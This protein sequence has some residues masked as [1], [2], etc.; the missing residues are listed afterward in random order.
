MFEFAKAASVAEADHILSAIYQESPKFWAAGLTRQHFDGGLWLIRKQASGEAIGFTGWQVRD[1]LGAKGMR[2]VGYYA[3]GLLPE[4]RGNGFAKE[5]VSRMLAQK[6]AEVDIVRALIHPDNAPS[7]ALA[8]RLGVEVEK[9]ARALLKAVGRGLGHETSKMVGT[10]L[11]TAVFH[12]QLMH[13][14]QP[15]TNSLKPWEWNKE[16]LMVGGVNFGMGALGRHYMANG[17]KALGIAT[18]SAGPIA[19]DVLMRTHGAIDSLRRIADKPQQ[20]QPSSGPQ[21]LSGKEKV[22]AA[23]L[24]AA[25]IGTVGF[26]ASRIAGA[27]NRLATANGPKARV[28]LP[29]KDPGDG[30]TTLEVAMPDMRLSQNIYRGLS[31]DLRGRLRQEN[32]ERVGKFRKTQTSLHNMGIQ[33]ND[34]GEIVGPQAVEKEEALAA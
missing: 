20:S 30:E 6:S 9:R 10:G 4:Y 21:G 17:D 31:R 12:D 13:Q 19:K 26:A 29:T 14:D 32:K 25:G 2:K 7:L 23:L 22:L 5:A 16:R 33:M 24:A 8:D 15:L 28:T 1:E 27:T 3:I 11:G 18:L 34:A